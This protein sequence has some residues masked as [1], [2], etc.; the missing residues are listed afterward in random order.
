M[1]TFAAHVAGETAYNKEAYHSQEIAHKAE[2]EPKD[3]AHFCTTSA[4]IKPSR[5]QEPVAYKN[6]KGKK[7]GHQYRHLSAKGWHANGA[8]SDGIFKNVTVNKKRFVADFIDHQTKLAQLRH[9]QISR[10]AS[11]N[12]HNTN[13]E[14]N[15]PL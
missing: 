1:A 14:Q 2:Y 4:L 5:Y 13:A 12:Q 11:T 15:K 3:A 8:A 7:K 9:E 6:Q 10:Y